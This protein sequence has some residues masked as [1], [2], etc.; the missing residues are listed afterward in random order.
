MTDAVR[1]P[2]DRQHGIAR[3][4]ERVQHP[5]PLRHVGGRGGNRW[6][7]NGNSPGVLGMSTPAA[8]R[9]ADSAVE[10]EPPNDGDLHRVQDRSIGP[11]S[12]TYAAICRVTI[13]PSDRGSP[14]ARVLVERHRTRPH[15]RRGP[16]PLPP[17]RPA[18]R[19]QGGRFPTGTVLPY[20]ER[21]RRPCGVRGARCGVS[22]ADRSC[23]GA[24]LRSPRSRSALAITAPESRG[25]GRGHHRSGVA[26]AARPTSPRPPR[27]AHVQLTAKKKRKKKLTLAQKR[28][29]I[30]QYL[31]RPPEGRDACTRLPPREEGEDQDAGRAPSRDPRALLAKHTKAKKKTT[32]GTK[33]TAAAGLAARTSAAPRLPR[34]RRRAVALASDPS[35]LRHLALPC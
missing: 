25:T 14:T 35:P 12:A 3:V 29:V 22:R 34:P 17:A 18:T 19:G 7:L 28:A 31:R 13:S 2:E 1:P 6:C 16:A 11:C 24:G 32:K 5:E 9:C 33:G 26:G 15:R 10:P 27:P 30:E 23:D 20:P 8:T 21:S 4:G